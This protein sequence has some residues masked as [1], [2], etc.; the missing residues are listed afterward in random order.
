MRHLSIYERMFFTLIPKEPPLVHSQTYGKNYRI[1]GRRTIV[2]KHRPFLIF[3]LAL[4]LFTSCDSYEEV[5]SSQEVQQLAVENQWDVLATKSL[6]QVG[7]ILYRTPTDIGCYM[8]WKTP[9]S[10]GYHVYSSNEYYPQITGINNE[11]VI[12]FHDWSHDA[13]FVCLAIN[14]KKMLQQVSFIRITFFD[15]SKVEMAQT[16]EGAIF[17]RASKDPDRKLQALILLNRSGKELWSSSS[18]PGL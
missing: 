3:F 15:G 2:I 10:E 5:L 6:G 12:A 9:S 8:L 17:L 4:A 16:G 1:V 11:P 18:I 7:I 13:E 14:D